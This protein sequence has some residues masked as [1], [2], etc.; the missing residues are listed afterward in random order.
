MS[1]SW[2]AQLAGAG[3]TG[4]GNGTFPASGPVDCPGGRLS[5]VVVGTFGGASVQLQQLGP[6]GVTFV[7]LGAAVTSAGAQI[8]EVAPTQ[9]QVVITGGVAN[10]LFVSIGRVVA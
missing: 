4:A 3:V 8:V 10:S 2:A 7:N 6:D 5:L 1:A 9:L